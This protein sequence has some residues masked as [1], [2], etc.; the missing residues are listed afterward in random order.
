MGEEREEVGEEVWSGE[1]EEGERGAAGRRGPQQSERTDW[2]E[3]WRG[4][5]VRR[6]ETRG[7]ETEGCV[8]ET[9]RGGKE[10]RHQGE[11]EM[12]ERWRVT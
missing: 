2:G 6:E 4:E 12:G 3:K 8:R 7:R 9:R 10:N 1:G 11:T 5:K